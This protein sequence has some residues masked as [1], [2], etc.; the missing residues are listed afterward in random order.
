MV[1]TDKQI[2]KRLNK[3][4]TKSVIFNSVK[5]ITRLPEYIKREGVVEEKKQKPQKKKHGNNKK[6]PAKGAAEKN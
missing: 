2:L 1:L 5:H 4:F 6:T 3:E